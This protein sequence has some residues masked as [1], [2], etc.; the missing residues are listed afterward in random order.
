MTTA[1]E[2]NSWTDDSAESS[3]IELK[4]AAGEEL[5]PWERAELEETKDR[6]ATLRMRYGVHTTLE[7]AADEL[8]FGSLREITSREAKS[9]ILTPWKLK[10]RLSKEV[11]NVTGTPQPSIRNG[12]FHRALNRSRPWLN[13]RDGVAQTA[14]KQDHSIAMTHYITSSDLSH[15]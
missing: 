15:E 8:I 3:L 6:G 5:T 9:D 1:E 14:A 11:Y 2:I 12:M 7:E 13:S 10:N 4:I